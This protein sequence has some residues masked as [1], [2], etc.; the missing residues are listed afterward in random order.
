MSFALSVSILVVLS[1]YVIVGASLATMF[2]TPESE[3]Q[4]FDAGDEGEKHHQSVEFVIAEVH[5][6]IL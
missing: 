1:N 6:T 5:R 4:N 3:R 2:P